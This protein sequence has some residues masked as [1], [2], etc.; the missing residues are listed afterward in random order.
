[1]GSL[2]H[3]QLYQVAAYGSFI[4]RQQRYAIGEHFLDMAQRFVSLA[5]FG[6]AA[7]TELTTNHSAWTT[8]RWQK[9]RIGTEKVI[10]IIENR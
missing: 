4:Y 6:R 9:V 10:W 3:L 2:A 8:Y 5:S 7:T 1:M